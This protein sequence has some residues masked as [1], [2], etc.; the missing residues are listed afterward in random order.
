M[1]TTENMAESNKVTNTN[2]YE[3]NRQMLAE[4]VVHTSGI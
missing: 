3:L 1:E 4:A 2:D